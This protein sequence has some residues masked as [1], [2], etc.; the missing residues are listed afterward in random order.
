VLNAALG[1]VAQAQAQRWCNIGRRFGL[2]C[3]WY[4][5]AVRALWLQR[6]WRRVG[7]FLV[8]TNKGVFWRTGRG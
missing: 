3:A 2:V 4:M 8:V 5:R 6:Q 7:C 1:G